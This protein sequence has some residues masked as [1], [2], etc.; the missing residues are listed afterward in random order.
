MKKIL[1]FLALDRCEGFNTVGSRFRNLTGT[2]AK[3]QAARQFSILNP[4]FLSPALAASTSFIHSQE[5]LTVH[6]FSG[7][8]GM[9]ALSE[10]SDF[11]FPLCYCLHSA[12][13]GAPSMP[14]LN[15]VVIPVLLDKVGELVVLFLGPGGINS[16]SRGKK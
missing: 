3:W 7:A 14:V 1:M 12:G 15:L 2:Y 6:S 11:Y 8:C 16:N 13:T 4:V 9:L 5:G 10:C